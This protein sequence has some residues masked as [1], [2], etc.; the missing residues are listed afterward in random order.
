MEQAAAVAPR[1]LPMPAP[2][3]VVV[4]P[5][6]NLQLAPVPA[7]LAD[8]NKPSPIEIAT[9][10]K[11]TAWLRALNGTTPGLVPNAAFEA[12][13]NYELELIGRHREA[14]FFARLQPAVEAAVQTAL[15]PIQ[16]EVALLSAQRTNKRIRADNKRA[17]REFKT[18][19][20]LV[21][22]DAPAPGAAPG[23][24][25]VGQPPAHTF[26]LTVEALE[27]LRGKQ[28][29]VLQAQYGRR[30]PGKT[31]AQRR[32]VFRRWIE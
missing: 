4:P 25:P 11:Y 7:A 14:L 18:L 17:L 23:G 9:C 5:G 16:V 19:R 15:A 2:V 27:G 24:L 6:S 30:F 10:A 12:W 26:P 8:P 28:L 3:I 22:E 31:V 20:P 1:A 29:D 21:R 32:D 13:L